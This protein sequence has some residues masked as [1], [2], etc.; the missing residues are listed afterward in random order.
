MEKQH[1]QFKGKEKRKKQTHASIERLFETADKISNALNWRKSLD[2][3]VIRAVLELSA[4]GNHPT[5]KQL[6]LKM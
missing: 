3:W 6:P 5:K 1:F 4:F 2:I